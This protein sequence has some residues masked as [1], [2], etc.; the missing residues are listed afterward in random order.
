MIPTSHYVGEGSTSVHTSYLGTP[1]YQLLTAAAAVC[2]CTRVYA[3]VCVRACA[4]VC[5][6]AVA[7]N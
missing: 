5:A 3:C 6:C 1:I 7:A 4:C 2:V